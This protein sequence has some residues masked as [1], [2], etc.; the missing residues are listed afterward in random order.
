MLRPNA[1]L[2]AWEKK[3]TEYAQHQEIDVIRINITRHC[4]GMDG[5]VYPVVEYPRN[6][7]NRSKS[8]PPLAGYGSIDA[9]K[10]VAVL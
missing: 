4:V 6:R 5:I 9:T 7:L 8:S 3:A 10:S 1:A 2:V